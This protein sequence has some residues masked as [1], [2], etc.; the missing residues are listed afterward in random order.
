M[1]STKVGGLSL[2][3]TTADR[4]SQECSQTR[5]I[6]CPGKESRHSMHAMYELY[7][8][9]AACLSCDVQRVRR[10]LAT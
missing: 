2:A 7:P 9:H 5:K 10:E 8:L 4:P 1:S 3:P 6:E